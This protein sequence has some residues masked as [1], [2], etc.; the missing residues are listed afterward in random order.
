MF[1]IAIPCQTARTHTPNSAETV[2]SD[3]QF[4]C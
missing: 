1:L 3:H 4:A 2:E